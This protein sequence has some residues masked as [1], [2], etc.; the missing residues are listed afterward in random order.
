MF[1]LFP[2]VGQS[3][4]TCPPDVTIGDLG[5]IPIGPSDIQ[6]QKQNSYE[7]KDSI[8]W[9]LGKNTIKFG[10]SF[11]HYIPPALLLR[12]E[13][14]YWYNLAQYLVKLW[15]LVPGRTLRGAGSGSF[16]GTKAFSRDMFR[17]T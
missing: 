10:G 7:V 17:T 2:G 11:N 1:I 5:S 15:P 9:A 8:S 14:D 12:V 3:T 4:K 6:N 13:T 16:L